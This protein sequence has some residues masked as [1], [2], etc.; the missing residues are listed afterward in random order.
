MDFHSPHLPGATFA[1]PAFNSLL[2][3]L[4]E[5]TGELEPPAAAW[6]ARQ[7]SLLADTG[8]LGWVIPR[9]YGGSEIDGRELMLGYRELSVACL[10]TAFVLTQRNGACQR[11]A[12]CGNEELKAEL[13][14][15]LCTGELF[16]T[17]GVSHLTTSRQHL[18]K[19][20][21][22]VRETAAGFVLDGTVPWVTGATFAD[23]VV[24]GGTCS[25]G[26]QVLVA[27]PAAS[28]GVTQLEPPRL[29]A[30]NASQTG[31][32]RLEHVHVPRRLSIAG[33]VEDV[34]K[35]GSGGGAGSLTTSSLAVGAAAA[36]LA[37]MQDEAERRPQLAETIEPLLAEHRT[38]EGDVLT[39]ATVPFPPLLRGG[40]GGCDAT[41]DARLTIESIR[42][43]AN[44]LVLRATQAYL[45]ASKGAGFAAGHPAERAV[46]EA[47][48]F[49]VWSCP[50]PVLSA[51][52]REFACGWGT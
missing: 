11:I 49:L 8:V 48:F 24:T 50:Q 27:L 37:R 40:Q 7:F 25:D 33:P 43:R 15:P 20:S 22:A 10:V 2:R 12:G 41:P 18:S 17:V 9:A 45:A 14:P 51:A 28:E 39:A 47:L 36:A 26:R 1:G 46:R 42:H 35:R 23:Y 44:S 29:L 30:L 52:L 19:P 6:P 5:L 3:R 32:I 31:S 4:S 38:L 21:V 34:M 16:A 13:L